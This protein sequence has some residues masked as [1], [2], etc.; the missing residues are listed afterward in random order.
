M[1]QGQLI[2]D[3]YEPLGTAGAGGFGTVR[4]A[5]DPR[6]QRK[7]AIKTIQLSEID[8]H[9]AGLPGAQAIAGAPASTQSR[10][11]GVQPWDEFLAETTGENVLAYGEV[12]ERSSG[13]Q[14]EQIKQPHISVKGLFQN[15]MI[16]PRNGDVG[17][18]TKDHQHENCKNQPHA[19]ISILKC[20]Y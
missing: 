11:R 18:N 2:L 19:D 15:I 1:D 7:V 9:R 17:S 20:F 14:I 16:D 5:W 8:A 12:A 6:I 13:E 3:R 4:I 10:W